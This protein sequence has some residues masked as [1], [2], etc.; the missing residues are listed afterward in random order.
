MAVLMFQHRFADL[1]ERGDKRHTIRPR[2]KGRQITPGDT[3][4]LRKWADKA[5]RSKQ[6]ELRVERCL[7]VRGVRID[8]IVGR[9]N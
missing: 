2:R 1:V 9:C 8:S 3:L 5:Y 7:A 6:V 4:R